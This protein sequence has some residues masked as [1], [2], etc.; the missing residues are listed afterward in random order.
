MHHP[1]ARIEEKKFTNEEINL[2]VSVQNKP[3]I[4][5]KWNYIQTNNNRIVPK[6]ELKKIS[7]KKN[8]RSVPRNLSNG[9]EITYQNRI[10]IQRRRNG[11]FQCSDQR[12]KNH[13][14]KI[15]DEIIPCDGHPSSGLTSNF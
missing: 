12:D 7:F 8:L 3:E 5:A 13:K 4:W 14:K 2:T 1:K 6:L 11:S 15:L 10:T 9:K